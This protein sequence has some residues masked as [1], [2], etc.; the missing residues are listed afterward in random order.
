MDEFDKPLA[1]A[2]FVF[3]ENS[4]A[5]PSGTRQVK[6]I[7]CVTERGGVFVLNDT[8]GPEW[9]SLPPVPGTAY[10]AITLMKEDE[11]GPERA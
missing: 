8:V 2:T 4:V 5:S 6:E 3:Q 11:G 7:I 1:I 10:H 9:H